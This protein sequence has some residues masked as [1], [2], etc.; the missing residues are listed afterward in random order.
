[1]DNNLS[2]STSHPVVDAV[3]KINFS[4]D[5][6]PETWYSTITYANGKPNL[7]AIVIL[8]DIVSWYSP[9][10]V[11]DK[12]TVQLVGYKKKFKTDKLQIT[13]NDIAKKFGLSKRQVTDAIVFLEKEIGVI[14][15]EF[16][17]LI[18]GGQKVSNILFIG[19]NPKKL[20]EITYMEDKKL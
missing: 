8:A 12:S 16:R 17:S 13:Y 19:I 9:H 1:M 10:E 18:V 5:I 2:L 6:I 15:R 7:N 14:E 4:G 3:E 20:S 11:R